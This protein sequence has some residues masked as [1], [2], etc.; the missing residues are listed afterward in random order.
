MKSLIC[1]CVAAAALALS[2][3]PTFGTD[4]GT[5]SASVT[6]SS[7]C[8]TVQSASLDFGGLSFSTSASASPT[9]FKELSDSFTN[10]SGTDETILAR[11]T[12]AHSAT[13]SASWQLGAPPGCDV[14]RYTLQIDA[15]AATVFP[16]N[17]NVN[18]QSAPSGSTLQDGFGIYMPC[19]GSSGAGEKMNFQYILTAAF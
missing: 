14:D 13:S 11:G 9:S 19:T 4:T 16:T 10:C 7:P 6:A 12:D 2:A 18:M 1:S 3:L 17:V 5:I 8:I 15:G